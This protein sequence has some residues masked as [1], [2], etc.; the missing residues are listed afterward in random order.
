VQQ[1]VTISTAAYN[2]AAAEDIFYTGLTPSALGI[3]GVQPSSLD[4]SPDSTHIV[5]M[6]GSVVENGGVAIFSNSIYVTDLSGNRSLVTEISSSIDNSLLQNPPE[7][8]PPEIQADGMMGVQYT[9]DGRLIYKTVQYNTGY[10][11]PDGGTQWE[12]DSATATMTSSV[13]MIKTDGSDL[14]TVLQGETIVGQLAQY[15]LYAHMLPSVQP[16]ISLPAL[17]ANTGTNI[18]FITTFALSM[19][20]LVMTMLVL[21]RQY[22]S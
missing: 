2:C 18:W 8:Q 5:Y 12:E 9:P 1:L 21:K 3:G 10:T 14:R 6:E 15:Q 11:Y 4:W 19:L 20:A 16:V 22:I 17:L 7:T 13:A